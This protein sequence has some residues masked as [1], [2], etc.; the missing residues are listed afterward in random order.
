M[1]SPKRVAVVGY[2]HLGKFLVQKI[3]N[4]ARFQLVFV[5]NRSEITDDALDKGLILANLDEFTK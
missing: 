1:S 2:G 3:L 4:D 5:W